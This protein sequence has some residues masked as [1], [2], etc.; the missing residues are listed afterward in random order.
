[1]DILGGHTFKLDR[2]AV[3]LPTE[4]F[5][6]RS[7]SERAKG[8]ELEDLPDLTVLP[9]MDEEDDY[10][11]SVN[12]LNEIGLAAAAKGIDVRNPDPDNPQSMAIS[13]LWMRRYKE[14]NRI[15][16]AVRASNMMFEEHMKNI[17]DPRMV[18]PDGLDAANLTPQDVVKT[19]NIA[20]H[21]TALDQLVKKTNAS[22]DREFDTKAQQIVH[23]KN[24]DEAKQSILDYRKFLTDRG[25]PVD[26]ADAIV[27]RY[28]EA[29][30]VSTYNS[31]NEKKFASIDEHRKGQRAIA[32]Q[33]EARLAKGGTDHMK[34]IGLFR[35]INALMN[36]K[37][38]ENLTPDYNEGGIFTFTG[39]DPSFNTWRKG[40]KQVT[41]I[42]R[43]KNGTIEAEITDTETMKKSNRPFDMPFVR[44]F[45]PTDG[46]K[47]S[48]EKLAEKYGMLDEFGNLTPVDPSV[49]VGSAA[50]STDGGQ[51]KRKI[52][53]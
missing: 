1:M 10:F 29:L 17:R 30:G 2:G 40:T 22:S 36:G 47:V 14:F 31:L 19:L 32:R 44:D 24:I 16:N 8:Y 25:A 39:D 51:E 11:N 4:E 45:A 46:I 27:T 50:E 33:R 48:I 35:K 42:K 38:F 43:N 49:L 52:D 15:G 13:R 20:P 6:R 41:G 23:Q 12:V 34:H 21:I 7:G 37:S 53:Y 5:M 18:V 26:L 9:G 28:A 3:N